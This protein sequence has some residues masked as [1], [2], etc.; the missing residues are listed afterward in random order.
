[1]VRFEEAATT[2]SQRRKA[3]LDQAIACVTRDRQN[4]YGDAEDN[5]SDIAELANVL[6]SRKLREKLSATDV[7]VF[8]CCIKMARIKSSPNHADNWVDLAGYAA[9]GG[10]I[11]AN[12][13]ADM[14]PEEGEG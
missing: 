2:G 6:L 9:C 7:A 4:T 1:M 12:K 8:C 3:I 10:G 14:H 13:P 5:F 11:E